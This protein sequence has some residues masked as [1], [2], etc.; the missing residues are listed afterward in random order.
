[1]RCRLRSAF[2]IAKRKRKWSDLSGQQRA[3][4]LV[5]IAVQAVLTAFAQRDLSTRDEDLVRGPKVLWRLL[6]F[7]T[8]GAVA[9]VLVGR[10]Y[11]S[12]ST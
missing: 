5:L 6:V 10:R 2:V 8:L 1:M 11:Q 9:Y 4:L 12:S 7:N 3:G